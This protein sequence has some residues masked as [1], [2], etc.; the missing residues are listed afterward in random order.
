MKIRIRSE[1]VRLRLWLPDSLLKSKFILRKLRVN[2]DREIVLKLY[3]EFKKA[4]K[5]FRGLE[6]V[7]VQASDGTVVVIKF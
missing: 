3:R 5:Q 1:G 6:I 7:H 2:I 4:K